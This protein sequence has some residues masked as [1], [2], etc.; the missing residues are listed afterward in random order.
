M[1]RGRPRINLDEQKTRALATARDLFVEFGYAGVTTDLLAARCNISKRTVYQ[2]FNG[3]GALL[4]QVIDSHREA[5]FST[6]AGADRDAVGHLHGLFAIN[7]HLNAPAERDYFIL[8]SAWDAAQEVASMNERIGTL[9]AEVA[10]SLFQLMGNCEGDPGDLQVLTQML[11]SIVFG[12]SL[13]RHLG[14]TIDGRN[15]RI[16]AYLNRAVYL[17]V[18]NYADNS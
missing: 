1:P 16:H 5:L 14:E 2:F 15:R 18:R 6:Q 7:S 11:F 4:E 17:F 13:D 9:K 3:K 12:C 10:S 8:R